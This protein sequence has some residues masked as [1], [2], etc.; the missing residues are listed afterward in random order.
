MLG[1]GFGRNFRVRWANDPMQG[2][3]V[4]AVKRDSETDR[5][6]RRH[7]QLAIEV[8]NT[9]RHEIEQSY[10]STREITLDTKLEPLYP[11]I[12]LGSDA[13]LFRGLKQFMGKLHRQNSGIE[14]LFQGILA[15]LSPDEHGQLLTS[16]KTAQKELLKPEG[17]FLLDINV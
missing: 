6:N 11:T 5:N 15:N 4:E 7:R 14:S 9:L 10:G 3:S 12:L 2:Q 13:F 17:S 16:L 8:N 1:I